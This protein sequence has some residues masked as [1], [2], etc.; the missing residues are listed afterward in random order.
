MG[1][2]W[3]DEEF[4]VPVLQANTS[5]VPKSWEDEDEN[6]AERLSL[7]VIPS[8]A[9]I[10][11][12]KKRADD[13]AALLAK[14]LEF[15]L[16]EK[17]TPEERKVRERK[18]V[19]EGETALAGELFDVDSKTSGGPKKGKE[20]GASSGSVTSGIAGAKLKTKDD[21]VNFAIT[22]S[23]KLAESTSFNITSF[24]KELSERTKGSLTSESLT[25]IIDSLTVIRD[26]K[27]KTEDPQ[28]GVVVK[29]TKKSLK[30]EQKKH[31]DTFGFVEEDAAYSSY[32]NARRLLPLER[33]PLKPNI[34]PGHQ[35]L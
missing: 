5:G 35:I 33:L 11:A 17:E 30:A 18:K 28:K 26:S 1:D 3:E 27:K 22:V 6:E 12:A 10:E 4:E 9:Q 34:Q 31:E 32:S 7:P 24:L 14:K 20:L 23:A 13:E 25:D 16:L 21:H 8:P 15:A 19:E 29:K 2:S